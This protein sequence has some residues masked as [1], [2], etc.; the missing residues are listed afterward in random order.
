MIIMMIIIKIIKNGWKN[1]AFCIKCTY[2]C[3]PKRQM[4]HLGVSAYFVK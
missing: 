2:K 1:V 3:A 4:T